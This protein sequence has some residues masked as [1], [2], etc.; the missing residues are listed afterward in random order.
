[1]KVFRLKHGPR[2]NF[3]VLRGR[4]EPGDT[5]MIDGFWAKPMA[6]QWRKVRVA[7]RIESAADAAK[8][9]SDFAHDVSFPLFGA[10]A[11][12]TLQDVLE[13]NGELLPAI[14]DEA[15]YW[16]YNT[17]TVLDALRAEGT[18]IY[19]KSR[20]IARYAFEPEIVKD[21]MIFKLTH[22][23]KGTTLFV[24]DRFMARVQN[25]GLTGF[26]PLLVWTDEDDVVRRFDMFDLP[27][28]K[29]P[30]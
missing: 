7:R 13:S 20:Q 11:V 24:T 19:G 29:A 5:Q 14:C 3:A 30:A 18:E 8:P 17:L 21:A 25:A 15:A 2:G 10:R 28:E 26:E 4:D 1:M 9:L 22:W 12:V 16:Y 6:A 27:M 23:P